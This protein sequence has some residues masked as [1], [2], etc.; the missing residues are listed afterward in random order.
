[1]NTNTNT[2]KT[3]NT[4]SN[5]TNSTALS[6]FSCNTKIDVHGNTILHLALKYS[7]LSVIEPIYQLFNTIKK[8]VTHH[9]N[10]TNNTTNTNGLVIINQVQF[11]MSDMQYLKYNQCNLY[12]QTSCDI[13]ALYGTA[14][15]NM[16]MY[17]RPINTTNTSTTTSNTNSSTTNTSASANQ[18]I[19]PR[20]ALNNSTCGY[21]LARTK[22]CENMEINTNTGYGFGQY[23]IDDL[24]YYPIGH[25]GPE[26]IVWY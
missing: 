15:C 18:L 16:K 14:K 21:I 9:T 6:L 5:A 13:G 19:H 2:N 22:L 20:T 8:I 7:M 12:G 23:D 1:M 17:I 24:K 11:N 4:T 10:N 26:Y 25:I 3:N